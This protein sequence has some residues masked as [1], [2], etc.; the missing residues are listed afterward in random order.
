L[1]DGCES[2]G[3]GLFVYTYCQGALPAPIPMPTAFDTAACAGAGYDPVAIAGGNV[4]VVFAST[5]TV[6]G[7][8]TAT[9]PLP[10]VL[11]ANDVDISGT[12]KSSAGAGFACSLVMD[13]ASGGGGAGGTAGG[14]GG[15]GGAGDGGTNAS[16]S[17]V[18]AITQIRGGCVGGSG[19]NK[20]AA[21]G[22]G[23]AGFGGGV[24]YVI[25]RS[26]VTLRGSSQLLA[27]GLGGQG[28]TTGGNGGGGGGGGGGLIAIDTNG[29]SVEQNV[30]LCAEGG[31]GGGGAGKSTT[32]GDGGPGGDGCAL[33][34]AG[35]GQGVN[36][37]GLGGDG[38]SGTSG[39]AGSNEVMMASGGGGGGGGA[40]WI[41]G[42]GAG[43]ALA[44]GSTGPSPPVQ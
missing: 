37:G 44:I 10:L 22:T 25:G 42:F 2:F 5:I 6:P 21:S 40:G 3:T 28:G 17:P 26:S 8:L 30:H 36:G 41:F 24:I 18:S 14:S 43:T 16:A 23:N 38:D 39:M 13:G 4:C 15:A 19:D 34:P 29:L 35:G 11:V 33:F 7:G 27:P 1:V 32:S 31:A 12:I 20:S 9:G